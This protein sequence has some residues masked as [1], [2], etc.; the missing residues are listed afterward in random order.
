MRKVYSPNTHSAALEPNEVNACIDCREYLE[1]CSCG[2]EFECGGLCGTMLTPDME[3]E[4]LG[5][6]RFCKPCW[7]SWD[8]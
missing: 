1:E 4:S 5:P 6:E 8:D 2:S 7:D 3:Y